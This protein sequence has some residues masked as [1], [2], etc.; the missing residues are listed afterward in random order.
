MKTGQ[1]N[2]KPKQNSKKKIWLIVLGI[3]VVAELIVAGVLAFEG[4]NEGKPNA[5]MDIQTNYI[6]LQ[7][8]AVYKKYLRYE[9]TIQNRDSTI[10]FS[11]QHDDTAD[12]MEL[13]RL[14]FTETKPKQ[15]EGYLNLDDCTL[16]VSMS[17]TPFSY[18]ELEGMLA[19]DSNEK[20]A[21]LEAQYA[22]MLGGMSSIIESVQQDPRFSVVKDVSENDMRSVSLTYWDVSLPKEVTWEERTEGELYRVVFHGKIDDQIVKLYTISLGDTLAEASIGK[23]MVKGEA[24][25]VSVEVCDLKSSGELTEEELL[26]GYALLD[27]VNDVLRSIREDKNFY[28]DLESVV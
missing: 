16:Y 27:T 18:S 23:Y 8:P 2:T 6:T 13:F 5:M 10:V 15:I 4:K 26:T 3:V 11:M 7:Y 12:V 24:K 22:A 17:A 19:E 25:A 28:A 1:G 9:E 14:S 21:E 20:K